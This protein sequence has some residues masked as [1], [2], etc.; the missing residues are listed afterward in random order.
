MGTGALPA[1]FGV[2]S[3][4]TAAGKHHA[5]ACRILPHPPALLAR[6]VRIRHLLSL[7]VLFISILSHVVLQ[8]N[9]AL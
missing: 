1:L 5:G 4:G 3:G 6:P 8:S 7:P 2:D 9:D